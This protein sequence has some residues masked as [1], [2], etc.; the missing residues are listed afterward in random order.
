M[1]LPARPLFIAM[2]IGEGKDG[3]ERRKGGEWD[4]SIFNQ[5]CK[6]VCLNGWMDVSID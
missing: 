3:S 1:G 6:Y 5:I 4:K 2:V